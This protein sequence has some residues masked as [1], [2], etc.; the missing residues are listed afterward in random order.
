MLPEISTP[1]QQLV[2]ASENRH[3]RTDH[4]D[5]DLGGRS[6]RGGAVTL[7]VQI[8]KFL[9][10]TA[11]TIVVARLLAP[12]DYGLVGMVLV[13]I[14]FLGLFQYLGLPAAT[15]KWKELNH[16]QVSTLFWINVALSTVIMLAAFT[17]APL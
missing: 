10:S 14:S 2:A 17:I 5:D 12:Q 16:A 11:A 8:L 7:A 13:L 9:I 6:M 4:L 15:V 3:F 1:Q